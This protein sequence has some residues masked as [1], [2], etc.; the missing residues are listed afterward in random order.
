MLG[1]EDA[2]IIVDVQKDFCPG[3][4]LPVPDGNAVVAS[5]NEWIDTALTSQATIVASRDWH[6]LHHP[7]FRAEGGQWPPHCLQDTA[8]ARFHEELRLPAGTIIVSKGVRFDKDQYS[9]FDDTGLSDFLKTRGVSRVWIGGLALDVCVMA[10]A[11][12]AAALGFDTHVLRQAS[13]ALTPEGER[14]ATEAMRRNGIT[15]EE[16]VRPGP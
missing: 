5:L 11:C 8:G 3:G 1:A 14:S 16:K 13:R 15:M 6:P 12:D 9:A 7:S 4:A 2:L 10:T